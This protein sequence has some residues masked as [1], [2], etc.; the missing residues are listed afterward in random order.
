VKRVNINDRR[1]GR[2]PRFCSG[3]ILRDARESASLTLRVVSDVTGIASCSISD[4]E[5]GIAATP[6]HHV[7]VLCEAL[8]LDR[9]KLIEAILQD[10]LLEVGLIGYAVCVAPGPHSQTAA[11]ELPEAADRAGSTEAASGPHTGSRRG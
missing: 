7:H 11:T 10:K 6:L 1:W 9:A 8:Q 2:L 4:M 5:R 3:Q